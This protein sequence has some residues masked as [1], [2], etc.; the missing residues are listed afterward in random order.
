[1][2]LQWIFGYENVPIDDEM[3]KK[4][5]GLFYKVGFGSGLPQWSDLVQKMDQIPQHWSRG[6]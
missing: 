1:M 6:Q 3:I 2:F 5:A 4:L